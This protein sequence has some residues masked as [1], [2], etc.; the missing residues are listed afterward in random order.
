MK[1]ARLIPKKADYRMRAHINPLSSTTF[2]FPPHHTFVDWKKHYPL[3]FGGSSEDNFQITCNTIEHPSDYETPRN[4]E[5][6]NNKVNVIDI[7]CG[8]GGLLFGLAPVLPDKTILGMEIRDKLVNFV[9]E[10]I[11]GLRTQEPGKY[12]HIS[13]VRTNTMRHLCQYFPK[14]SLDKI[15]ICFPDPHFKA[16]NYRRRIINTGFL[17]EYAYLLKP[18]AKLYCITD[19]LE[20]HEWHLEHLRAHH[21]FEELNDK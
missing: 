17:S 19:V 1:G 9:G 4:Y 2:P 21:M 18:G 12:D 3:K 10:K 20:L 14:G 11:R 13:V 15:F 7:G 8:F 16:K 6:G 5:L